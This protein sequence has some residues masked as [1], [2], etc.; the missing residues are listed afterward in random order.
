MEGVLL[1]GGAASYDGQAVEGQR[2]L[3]HYFV[4]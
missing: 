3:T 4:V 1:P 2:S